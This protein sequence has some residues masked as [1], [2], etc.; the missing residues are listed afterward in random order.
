MTDENDTQPVDHAL[1]YLDKGLDKVDLAGDGPADRESKH[2]RYVSAQAHLLGS[3]A[4]SLYELRTAVLEIKERLAYPLRPV[5]PA[6][7]RE[8]TEEE[9]QEIQDNIDIAFGTGG[10]SGNPLQD[11][12]DL[13]LRAKSSDKRP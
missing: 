8:L 4:V 9:L 2:L 11:A 10:S 3:I 1:K 7:A 5:A 6:E 13:V 12:I